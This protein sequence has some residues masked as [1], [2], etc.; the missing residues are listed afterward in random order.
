MNFQKIKV[1]IL[2]LNIYYFINLLIRLTKCF[3]LRFG[4]V[5]L[6]ELSH[7]QCD[8]FLCIIQQ[9]PVNFVDISDTTALFV[10][11]IYFYLK[12]RTQI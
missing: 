5:Y 10:D 3:E 8:I 12:I 11:D 4:R 9:S 1:G 6:T 2:V 7:N